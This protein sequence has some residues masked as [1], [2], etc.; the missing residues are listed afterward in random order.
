MDTYSSQHP[1][2]SSTGPPPLSRPTLGASIAE[3]VYMRKS[4]F[5]QELVNAVVNICRRARFSLEGASIEGTVSITMGAGA[6]VLVGHITETFGTP[7]SYIIKRQQHQ[8]QMEAALA[9]QEQEDD[10]I[11]PDMNGNKLHP[12]RV[13]SVD[14]SDSSSTC[15]GERKTRSSLREKMKKSNGEVTG[16]KVTRI[17][18]NELL[19]NETFL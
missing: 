17:I 16:K 7:Q 11:Q 14:G 13:G 3:R 10:R 6:D 2:G 19:C 4:W 15:S 18:P 1:G 5:Q 8:R 12:G 9:R